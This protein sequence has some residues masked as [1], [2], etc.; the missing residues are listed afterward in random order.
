[1]SQFLENLESAIK[2]IHLSHGI[3]SDTVSKQVADAIAAGISPLQTELTT[4]QA[5]VAELQKA[6]QD[7]VTAISNG[8]S[9]GA[10][11]IAT[12]AANFVASSTAAT[13]ATNTTGTGETTGAAGTDETTA[14]ATGEAG[15]TGAGTSSAGTSS[16]GT[17]SAETAAA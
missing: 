10:Q 17:S 5:Q 12:A 7:T 14:A 13:S 15:T 6:A 16:A 3:D 11:A 8:D 2:N 1:M 4:L 9:A